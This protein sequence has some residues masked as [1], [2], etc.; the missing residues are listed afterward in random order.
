MITG[1]VLLYGSH[2]QSVEARASG[3]AWC[4]LDSTTD[5]VCPLAGGVFA[6]GHQ[7][8]PE[9]AVPMRNR[10]IVTRAR[11]SARLTFGDQANCTLDEYSVIFPRSGKPDTLFTQKRGSASCVSSRP[12]RVRIMCG[13]VEPCPTE[14]RAKGEFLYKTLRPEAATASWTRTRRRRIEVVSC[15]GFIEVR[16]E[17]PGGVHYASGGGSPG[18]RTAIVIEVISKTVRSPW[19]VSVSEYASVRSN[20]EAGTPAAEECEASF[21]QEAEDTVTP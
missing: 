18:S 13:P 12:G 9:S 21:S 5:W 7:L 11:S 17:S 16:V 6:E 20:G 8:S 2:L 4:G 14:L 15:D 3:E 19:G 10:K 1:V